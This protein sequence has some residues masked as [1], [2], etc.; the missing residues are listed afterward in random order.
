VPTDQSPTDY[1]YGGW[2]ETQVLPSRSFQ[3]RCR[4]AEILSRE[5][6][7]ELEREASCLAYELPEGGFLAEKLEGMGK[8][9]P[10]LQGVRNQGQTELLPGLAWCQ[11]P[12]GFHRTRTLL[13]SLWWAGTGWVKGDSQ[14]WGE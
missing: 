5:Q 4:E 2:T 10:R 3:I 12:G 13:F 9:S 14:G 6:L 7:S 11:D 1:S 8:P